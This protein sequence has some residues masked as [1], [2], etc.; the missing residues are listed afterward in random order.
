MR[1]LTRLLRYTGSRVLLPLLAIGSALLL[2]PARPLRSDNF[3]FYFPNSHQVLPIETINNTEYL[4]LLKVLNLTVKV[5]G[6]KEKG[7]TIK[8]WLGNTRLELHL[9]DK[10]A[11]VDQTSVTLANPDRVSN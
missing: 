6:L 11:H 8:V 2:W 7:K 9:D 1:A 10:R 4:P 3:I 5:T